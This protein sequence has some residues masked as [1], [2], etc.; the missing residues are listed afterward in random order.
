MGRSSIEVQHVP[1][2]LK[3][4]CTQGSADWQWPGDAAAEG[5]KLAGIRCRAVMS[6][7]AGREIC[8][9]PI[10]V[11]LV[12]ISIGDVVP[13]LRLLSRRKE[14]VVYDSVTAAI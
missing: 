8:S 1:N 10:T 5:R 11:R 14:M 4:R 9:P 12:R 3:Y 13:S 6:R 7:A 2:N